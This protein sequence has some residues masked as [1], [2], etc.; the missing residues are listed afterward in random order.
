MLNK[1]HQC[2]TGYPLQQHLMSIQGVVHSVAEHPA[3]PKQIRDPL[4]FGLASFGRVTM[5]LNCHCNGP[6]MRRFK[7]DR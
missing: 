5:W 2:R 4:K 6:V 1:M 7:H 3:A